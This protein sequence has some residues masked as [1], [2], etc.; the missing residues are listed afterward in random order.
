MMGFCQSIR[1]RKPGAVGQDRDERRARPMFRFKQMHI[2]AVRVVGVAAT[3]LAFWQWATS[4]LGMQEPWDA[5][6]YPA[7]YFGS[8]GICAASGYLLPARPWRWALIIIFAQLPLMVLHTGRVGPLLVVGI[9]F[10]V[11]QA[12]PAI[13]AATA[14][15]RFRCTK[16]PK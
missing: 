12:L 1:G 16:R 11:L 10:L 6:D 4:S 9:G 2:E 3:G 7:F 13:L 15:S 5:P 8:L 14:A